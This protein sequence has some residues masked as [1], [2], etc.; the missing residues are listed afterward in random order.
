MIINTNIYEEVID[1]AKLLAKLKDMSYNTSDFKSRQFIEDSIS[2]QE[3][4]INKHTN[5]S[6]NY[7]LSI[8]LKMTELEAKISKQ[9]NPNKK[10]VMEK[11]LE[12]YENKIKAKIYNKTSYKKCDDF[13]N[14]QKYDKDL[15]NR[16]KD[17]S[18][19]CEAHQAELKAKENN[20]EVELDN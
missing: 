2:L 17:I 15:L 6:C 12:I 4:F 19:M 14:S 8:L 1:R 16:V 11:S 5:N 13:R 3:K 18:K 9:R 10:A 7:V 20:S